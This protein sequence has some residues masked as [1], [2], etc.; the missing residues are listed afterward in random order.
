MLTSE[1]I[2]K[3]KRKLARERERAIE[4]AE[5]DARGRAA[6]LRSAK[7]QKKAK[8]KQEQRQ[9]AVRDAAIAAGNTP[10]SKPKRRSV[11]AVSGGA[12]ET[13]RRKF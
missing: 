12:V 11:F 4:L 10:K 5:R 1:E 2:E 7:S 13:N 8:S 6:A 9:K 3:L